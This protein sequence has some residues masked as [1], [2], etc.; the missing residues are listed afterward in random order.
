M[1]GTG[2]LGDV[3]ANVVDNAQNTAQSPWN[4]AKENRKTWEACRRRSITGRHPTVED[5]HEKLVE[6]YIE[7]KDSEREEEKFVNR[8]RNGHK[9][10]NVDLF[11]EIPADA[12]PHTARNRSLFQHMGIAALRARE[13]FCNKEEEAKA[14]VRAAEAA[15]R[16]AQA[17]DANKKKKRKAASNSGSSQMHDDLVGMTKEFWDARIPREFKREGMEA[18]FVQPDDV[19]KA[20]H[21]KPASLNKEGVGVMYGIQPTLPGGVKGDHERRGVRPGRRLLL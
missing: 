11:R 12:S 9:L 19:A 5:A 14:Q 13:E 16:G 10:D 7:E 1:H 6:Y 21:E 15:A 18:M 8:M 17:D 3:A 20:I 2:P 4:A